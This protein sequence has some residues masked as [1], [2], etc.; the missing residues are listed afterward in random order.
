MHSNG[1][2]F[3][4]F[5]VY[6]HMARGLYNFSYLIPKRS[7]WVTGVLIYLLMILTAFTGYVLP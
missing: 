5:L 7:V 3:F 6:M 4:F 2:S 1:A